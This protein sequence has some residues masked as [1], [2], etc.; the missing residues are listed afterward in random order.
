MKKGANGGAT[1]D[2]KVQKGAG[3]AQNKNGKK[4]EKGGGKS[5]MSLADTKVKVTEY[6]TAQNRPYSV[7]DILNCFQSC[8]RKKEAD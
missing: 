7:Q 6:L 3:A 4:N 2:A 5:I 8:M 1:Q